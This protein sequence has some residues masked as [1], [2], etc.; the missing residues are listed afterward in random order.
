MAKQKALLFGIS[1]LSYGYFMKCRLKFL[2]YLLSNAFRGVVENRCFQNAS[3]A[4]LAVLKMEE[5]REEFNELKGG[6]FSLPLVEKT[7]AKLVNVPLVASKDVRVQIS[8]NDYRKEI[9][10]VKEKILGAIDEGPVIAGLMALENTRENVCDVSGAIDKML[11]DVLK[12]VDEF[13]VFSPY[14]MPRKGKF[15]P[16][17]VFLSTRPR[18]HEH[19]TIKLWEIG[20]IFFE[21]ANA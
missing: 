12:H 13:I 8:K 15:E 7:N 5:I 19:E 2:N 11:F 4:W 14:G 6:V 3:Y 16:Y 10:I 21:M 1:A 17:G 20:K 18:P 9:G